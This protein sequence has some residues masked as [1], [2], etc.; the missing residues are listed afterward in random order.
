MEAILKMR[1]I[2]K[3]FP[4]VV[5]NDKV[6]LDLY[7][8]E[9]HAL[10]G[11]NGAGK[12]T[13][14]NILTGIYRQNEGSIY[15]KGKHVFLKNPKKAV[16]LGI[17]MV[18]Q[19]F[20]LIE[21]LTVAENIFLGSEKCKFYLKSSEM[22]K[23]IQKYSAQYNL[24]VDPDAKIWQLSVGE[25]QRVEIIKLLFRGADVLIL[26]EPTAVLTP[27][28]SHDLFQIL[29][30][31]ADSGKS[32][33]FITHKMAEVMNYSDRI[34]VMKDGTTVETL[35]RKDT[36]EK[37]LT[38][39]TIGRSLQ[40][41]R[42]DYSC[43]RSECMVELSDVTVLND[44]G[45][46]AA[47]H[48]NLKV[49]RKEILGIAGVAG[50]GQRELSEAIAG[51]RPLEGGKIV[52]H[53]GAAKKGNRGA[54]AFIPEDRLGTGLVQSMNMMENAILKDYKTGRFSSRG[55]LKKDRIKKFTAELERD[56][57]IKNAGIGCPVS[58]MSGGNQQKLLVAREIN[59]QPEII[60]AT[61]PVRGL[62]VG[63]TESINK[64]LLE[65]RDRG[66][67]IILI[68]E[69]L[70]Q[71]FE[72]SDTIAVLYNHEIRAVYDSKDAT[73][74]K[75]GNNMIGTIDMNCHTPQGYGAMGEGASA[76]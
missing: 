4:G 76:S 22:E 40:K 42:M 11:E 34:T 26:D 46:C 45:I 32:I 21:P 8:G 48:V 10:L 50:N 41:V 24:S 6:N 73:L 18:H 38:E 33:V 51:L 53:E 68:S 70:D 39:L 72:M 12:S 43:E 19:H 65:Q 16:D 37:K 69:D 60:I 28:E 2:T 23:E 49:H 17:G 15:Y 7:P 55:I 44:K 36:D 64:I 61:Y 54:I 20:K 29:R 27:K 1:N 66:A 30:M 57:K 56:Y 13:L 75:V 14:M 71:I 31:M 47:N 59:G 63:A 9:I 35:L 3:R 67:A 74:E 52:F 25:Q 5:A 58:L 62:D